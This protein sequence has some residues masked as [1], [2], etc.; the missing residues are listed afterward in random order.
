MNDSDIFL[1]ATA[2]NGST[3]PVWASPMQLKH[4]DMVRSDIDGEYYTLLNNNPVASTITTGP[5]NPT[6]ALDAWLAG[7][8]KI[9]DGDKPG[10]IITVRDVGNNNFYKFGAKTYLRT[11]TLLEVIEADYPA[12]PS[13]AFS[14]FNSWKAC[15]VQ[16]PPYTISGVSFGAPAGMTS[17]SYNGYLLAVSASSITAVDVQNCWYSSD[18]GVQWYPGPTIGTMSSFNARITSNETTRFWRAHA[19]DANI[20]SIDPSG[21]GLQGAWTRRGAH[22]L[23][24][25]VNFATGTLEYLGNNAGGDCICIMDGGAIATTG[26]TTAFALSVDGG[27]GFSRPT[28]FGMNASIKG[29]MVLSNKQGHVLL[30]AATKITSPLGVQAW[31]SGGYGSNLVDTFQSAVYYNVCGGCWDGEK[32]VIA[33]QRTTT[34]V[35]I[36][37][38][39][40]QPNNSVVFTLVSK[41]SLHTY[42][43]GDGHKNSGNSI[44]FSRGQYLLRMTN[45]LSIFPSFGALCDA[46]PTAI[47]PLQGAT[48]LNSVGFAQIG[49]NF[50]GF[51]TN[52]PWKSRLTIGTSTVYKPTPETVSA[53]RVL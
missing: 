50:H 36:F 47:A 17:G 40:I 28:L 37:T 2:G 15:S 5:G 53:I 33:L 20:W 31:A 14:V 29:S 35:D 9:G 25:G 43:I 6:T 7:W 30:L 12:L 39:Y 11:G 45:K 23:S 13:D 16:S 24:L 27:L 21:A 42:I 22:G 41:A 32:Y 19:G 49:N 4:L 8:R 44:H 52:T 51:V 38:G 34:A 10:D 18:A 48:V 46:V 3:I 26:V 1:E